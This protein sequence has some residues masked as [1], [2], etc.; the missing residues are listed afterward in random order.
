MVSEIYIYNYSAQ[1]CIYHKKAA[2]SFERK[3]LQRRFAATLKGSDVFILSRISHRTIPLEMI[4][5]GQDSI[6][7]TAS[8]Y[9]LK[10]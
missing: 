1:F 9:A 6:Q 2:I 10:Y 4:Y 5:L 3:E 8:F 7:Y